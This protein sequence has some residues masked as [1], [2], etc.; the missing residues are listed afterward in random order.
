MI[1]TAII[2]FGLSGRVFHAPFIHAHEGFNLTKVVQRH[3]DSAIA[4]ALGDYAATNSVPGEF[5]FEST[6]QKRIGISSMNNYL[7]I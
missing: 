3:G 5:E 2:G 4:L 7:G 6:G 1:I